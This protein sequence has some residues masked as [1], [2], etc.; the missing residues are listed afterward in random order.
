MRTRY[1][2]DKLPPS[3]TAMS[4]TVTD[5]P[6]T[7]DMNSSVIDEASRGSSTAISFLEVGGP[8]GPTRTTSMN[9]GW[10]R[11]S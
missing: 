7:L 4:S 3:S 8:P 11:R 6:S 2:S 10:P 5:T 1:V 9:A